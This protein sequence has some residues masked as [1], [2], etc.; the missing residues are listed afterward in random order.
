MKSATAIAIA[1]ALAAPWA[2]VSAQAP[3]REEIG[4]LVADGAEGYVNGVQIKARKKYVIY[5]GDTISTGRDTSLRLSLTADGY[6]GYIQLDEDTDP[7]L[8]KKSGCIAMEM[9]KGRAIINAK[10]ICMKTPR[11]EGVTKSLVHLDVN[12]QADT[13]TVI[14]GSVDLQ[15]PIATTVGEFWRYSVGADGAAQA[16]RIDAAEAQRTIEWQKQY[17]RGMPTWLKAL[18]V[19][20][21]AYALHEV[22]DDKDRPSSSPPP[23]TTPS[24]PEGGI[25]R[26]PAPPDRPAV[27]TTPPPPPPEVIPDADR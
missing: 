8:L 16:Q 7:N 4:K 19:T 6:D 14:K 25:D 26:Y 27:D 22:I 9:L 1:I 24:P 5:D 18:L 20:L 2:P 23:S 15:A 3:A 13:L 17:F 10:R 12:E 21:G 11:L